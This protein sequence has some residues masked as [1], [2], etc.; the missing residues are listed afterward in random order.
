MET[1]YYTVSVNYLFSESNNAKSSDRWTVSHWDTLE[2]P[3]QIPLACDNKSL[4]LTTTANPSHYDATW[5]W[6]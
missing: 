3:F 4:Q 6:Y 1:P 5:A 2:E